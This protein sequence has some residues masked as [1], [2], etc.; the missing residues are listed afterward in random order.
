MQIEDL[1]SQKQ[2]SI[3]F[4]AGLVLFGVGM[5]VFF[6]WLAS[7]IVT[8]S[9]DGDAAAIN[10]SGSL[11]MQAYRI[12]TVLAAPEVDQERLQAETEA[13]ES[14]LNSPVLN[15]YIRIAGEHHE[16]SPAY[17]KVTELWQQE[18][19]P[20]L[21]PTSVQLEAHRLRYLVLV[22]DF[23]DD[24]ERM[25]LL[26][27]QKSE[28]KVVLLRSV[29]GISLFGVV[30]VIAVA[31][32]GL[33]LTVIAPLNDLVLAAEKIR[34]GD[35]SARVTYEGNDELGLL[36]ESFNLMA[37][38][39]SKLYQDLEQRVATKTEKLTQANSAL[40][41]VYEI[42]QRLS[43]DQ[44]PENQFSKILAQLETASSLSDIQ[45]CIEVPS[46]SNRLLI[47]TAEQS[48]ISLQCDASQ[49]CDSCHACGEKPTASGARAF[50]RFPIRDNEKRYGT[51]Q[52]SS[53]KDIEDWER[54]LMET[55]AESFATRLRLS[56]HSEQQ[57]R[58]V[59]MEERA[60]IAREL[61]DSLAQALSYLKIQVTLLKNLWRKEAPPEMTDA[62]LEGLSSGLNTAYRQL[63][64]LLTTF[65]LT[66][67]GSGLESTLTNTV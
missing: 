42:S 46:L 7:V 20:L 19:K 58:I 35:M 55:V 30:I 14:R 32:Y 34:K 52:A 10:I 25:V 53:P 31:M 23:V 67:D 21:N 12:A 6:S 22:D 11:R 28:A 48:S 9:T 27:Q 24:V 29:G 5:L 49:L 66:T 1:N 13:F 4:R 47:T 63:R 3:I 16:L 62:A 61:H 33:R 51:L 57:R 37:D 60:V 59:L 65:R 50:H 41:L 54:R 17:Q 39:L 64:E 36:G 15:Q 45:L 43:H 18:M 2:H 44:H 38:E 56:K 8:E 26:I 40:A